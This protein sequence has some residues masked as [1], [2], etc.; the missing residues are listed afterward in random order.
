MEVDHKFGKL[1]VKMIKK[2]N[3]G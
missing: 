1:I 3:M 2:I